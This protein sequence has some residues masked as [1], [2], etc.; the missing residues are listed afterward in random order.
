MYLVTEKGK[1]FADA[2]DQAEKEVLAAFG[3]AGDFENSE[4]LTIYESGDGNAA[5]LAVSVLMHAE[6][7]VAGLGK[8]VEK[9]AD[10]FAE[11]GKWKDSDTKKAISEWAVEATANGKLDSIRKNVEASQECG[12]VERRRQSCRI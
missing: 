7:D 5:L 11:T 2:K 9:F 8:R 12:S 6:T 4:D 10:S 3:I 1:T